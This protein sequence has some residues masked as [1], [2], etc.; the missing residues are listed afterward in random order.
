MSQPAV[1]T[2]IG[3]AANSESVVRL[4]KGLQSKD[5]GVQILP[6]LKNS[7]NDTLTAKKAR[8][9]INAELL[10]EM[11]LIGLPCNS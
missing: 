9:Q 10:E 3:R 7:H 8:R 11:S 1:P 2:G 6:N 5:N 4:K